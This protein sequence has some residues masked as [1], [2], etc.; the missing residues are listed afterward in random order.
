MTPRW[1]RRAVLAV[2][3]LAIAGMIVASITDHVGTAIT[4]GLIASAALV[5]LILVTAVAGPNACG[6][7]PPVDEAAAADLERKIQQLV[8]EG[9]D[10]NAVR[11]LVRAAARLRRPN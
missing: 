1:I 4:F 7:Q 9:A 3:V 11:S 6:G 10:E 8:A 2:C 5:A